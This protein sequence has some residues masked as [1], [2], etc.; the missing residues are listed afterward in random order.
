MSQ[1]WEKKLETYQKI[2]DHLHSAKEAADPRMSLEAVVRVNNLEVIK[3]HLQTNGDPFSQLVN[4]NALI[5]GYRNY[6]VT[7]TYGKVSYWSAGKCLHGPVDFDKTFGDARKYND[8]CSGNSFW[9]EGVSF[10]SRIIPCYSLTNGPGPLP[11]LVYNTPAW[12][13]TILH[14]SP[15]TFQHNV[16]LKHSLLRMSLIGLISLISISES[17]AREA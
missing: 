12:H 17:L 9:V 5:D 11:S 1:W 13:N 14:S 10:R 4:V 2:K 8:L 3:N 7:W 15:V 6:T 16:S